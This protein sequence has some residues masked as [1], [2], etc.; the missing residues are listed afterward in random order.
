MTDTAVEDEITPIA[1]LSAGDDDGSDR[2]ARVL[3]IVVAAL[4][5]VGLAVVT[6]HV[7]GGDDRTPQERLRA[8]PAAVEAAKTFA[9]QVKAETAFGTMSSSV[10][11][12]GVV[13]ATAKRASA[14]MDLLGRKLEIVTD[15]AA[16]YVKV[17]AEARGF[18]QG[19]GWIKVPADG[20]SAGTAETSPT[21]SP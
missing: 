13:D 4:L 21:A 7:V 12:D 2:S 6:L 18:S 15:G 8:A 20:V 14:T 10:Q 19:K 9:Y 16:T 11:L 5:A 1:E 17:P 3:A